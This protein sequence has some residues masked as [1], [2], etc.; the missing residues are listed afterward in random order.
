MLE[1]IL[2]GSNLAVQ[3]LKFYFCYGYRFTMSSN[4]GKPGKLLDREGAL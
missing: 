4:V 3:A 2:R 1:A